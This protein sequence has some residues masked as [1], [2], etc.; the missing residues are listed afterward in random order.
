MLS[1]SGC[2]KEKESFAG[3]GVAVAEGCADAVG[4]AASAMTKSAAVS[5]RDRVR[6]LKAIKV[7]SGS[8]IRDSIGWPLPSLPFPPTRWP[9]LM[10]RTGT[11]L[12]HLYDR[13]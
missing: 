6:R 2:P 1:R 8:F 9:A 7:V 12:T 10:T 13:C 5:I 3:G 4:A 11:G